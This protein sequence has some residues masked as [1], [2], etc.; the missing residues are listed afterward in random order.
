MDIKIDNNDFFQINELND[1]EIIKS[2]KNGMHKFAKLYA[3]EL[4][5][6]SKNDSEKLLNIIFKLEEYNIKCSKFITILYKLLQLLIKTTSL[7]Q[8][9]KYKCPKKV[10]ENDERHCKKVDMAKKFSEK[11]E[12]NM[13]TRINSYSIF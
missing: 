13:V 11:V 7:L 8:S 9:S 4:T 2:F 10:V 1:D 6:L 3:E 5:K 12:K